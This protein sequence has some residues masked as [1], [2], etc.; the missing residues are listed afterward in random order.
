MV[1]HMDALFGEKIN[2]YCCE[3]CCCALKPFSY[4]SFSKA[5][6]FTSTSAQDGPDFKVA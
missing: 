3:R 4:R 1:M 6:V 5:K 2:P